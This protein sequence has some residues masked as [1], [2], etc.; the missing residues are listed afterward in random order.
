MLALRI[1]D[2]NIENLLYSKFQKIDEIKNYII[3][4]ISKDLTQEHQ[5]WQKDELEYISKIDLSTPLEDNE[6]YS[7]W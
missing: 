6:D 7:K 3:N 4:L 1:D 2:K 5:L